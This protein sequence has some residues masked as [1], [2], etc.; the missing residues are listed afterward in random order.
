MKK[1]FLG[2]FL[3][4]SIVHAGVKNMPATPQ[5]VESGITIIDIRTKPE[6]E[7]TG[8]V[9]NSIPITFFDERGNYDAQKFLDM[10]SGVVKKGEE[11]AIICRS[12]NRTTA[13]SQFLAQQGYDVINLQGGVK[14]LATQGYKLSKYKP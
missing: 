1:I 11:F 4:L 12:G 7:Q 5:I 6:W 14:H 9:K 2:L 3:L 10:L 13:V 8:I